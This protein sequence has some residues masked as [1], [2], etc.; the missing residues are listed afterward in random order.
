MIYLVYTQEDFGEASIKVS[1]AYIN[2]TSGI[3]GRV[4]LI[5]S[6]LRNASILSTIHG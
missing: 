4:S 3:Y 6:Y 5:I 2:E 1:S